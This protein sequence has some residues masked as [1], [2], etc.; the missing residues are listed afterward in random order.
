MKQ[1]VILSIV[2]LVA[3]LVGD[4]FCISRGTTV[5]NLNGFEYHVAVL[6]PLY[7]CNGAIVS[8]RNVLTT[9]SC[10]NLLRPENVDVYAGSTQYQSGG[11]SYAV[12]NIRWHPSFRLL[13]NEANIAILEVST[14]FDYS[15]GILP[16]PLA[17]ALAPTNTFIIGTGYGAVDGIL[18]YPDYLQKVSLQQFD[19]NICVQYYGSRLLSSMFCAGDVS[20]LKDLCTGDEGAPVKYSNQLVGIYS[21]GGRCGTFDDDQSS[22]T[23]SLIRYL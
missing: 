5:T 1:T 21:W 3:C 14:P 8:S 15:Q 4:G 12:S 23:S 2:A 6:C 13:T 22:I 7:T 9:A 11:V 10:M 19:R 17:S 20:G 16:I 18:T